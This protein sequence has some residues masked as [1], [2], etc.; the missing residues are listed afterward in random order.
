MTK[1][2]KLELGAQIG[3]GGF[4]K[5]FAAKDPI[6]GNVAAKVLHKDPSLSDKEWRTVRE[7]IFKEG[8]N[9]TKAEHENIVRVFY[10]TRSKGDPVLV[11]EFCGGGSLQTQYEAGPLALP[12]VKKVA[13]EVCFGLAA[14]HDRGMLHRDIKPSNILLDDTGRAKLTDFGL[15]TDDLVL[16]YASAQGYDD[17]VAKEV[18]DG[19]GTSKKTDIWAVGMTLYRLIHGKWWY[20]GHP[21]PN[22]IV[23]AGGFAKKLKWLPHVPPEWRRLIRRALHD[24]PDL[25]FQSVEDLQNAL[26]QVPAPAWNCSITPTLIEWTLQKAGRRYEVSWDVS[27]KGGEWV[28]YS[29]DLSTGA[30]RKLRSGTGV[31]QLESFLHAHG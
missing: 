27:T 24:D 12:Y 15:A 3:Q 13:R 1:R 23:P 29:R 9:L 16:G 21:P 7:E 17:H 18:W 25:R 10:V 8:A 28:A 2:K 6:K 20:E 22:A 4:G 30:R 5:V 11:M 26:A 31:K 19:K 14:L